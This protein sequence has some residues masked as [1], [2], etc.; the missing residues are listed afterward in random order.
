MYHPS[1]GLPR[2]ANTWGYIA[3]HEKQEANRESTASHG[4]LPRLPSREGKTKVKS[5]RWRGEALFSESHYSYPRFK[6]PCGGHKR[7]LQRLSQKKQLVQKIEE[8]NTK[9]HLVKATEELQKVKA[10][11]IRK[12]QIKNKQQLVQP[13]PPDTEKRITSPKKNN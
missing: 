12:V 1:N 11:K 6:K 7:M 5:R 3:V 4:E 9:D 8:D 13:E 2:T 10:Y